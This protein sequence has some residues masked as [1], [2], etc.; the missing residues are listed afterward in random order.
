MTATSRRYRL[1]RREVL[2]R[3]RARDYPP[4]M[5]DTHLSGPWS[6]LR[7]EKGWAVDLYDGTRAGTFEHYETAALVAAILPMHAW[8]PMYDFGEGKTL[9]VNFGGSQKSVG[10][11]LLMPDSDCLEVVHA[12]ACSPRSLAW[13]LAATPAETLER[14]GEML[15]EF[16][17]TRE[18]AGQEDESE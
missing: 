16:L 14:A 1:F 17:E 5:N 15:G 12:L 8:T 2:D 11:Y 9:K 13:L 6:L 4:T 18:L 7:T 3:L 10:E